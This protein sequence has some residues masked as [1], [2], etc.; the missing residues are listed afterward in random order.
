MKDY[1]IFTDSSCDLSEESLKERGVIAL[2][3][4]FRFDGEEY[5]NY[6]ME[7]SEF[8]NNMRTRQTLQDE[9]AEKIIQLLEYGASINLFSSETTPFQIED[10]LAEEVSDK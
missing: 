1:V 5:S 2:P 9:N 4:S 8:Y 6:G 3:L 10:F 7:S